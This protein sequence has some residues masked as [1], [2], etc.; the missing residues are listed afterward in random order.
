MPE[1]PLVYFPASQDK[2]RQWGVL[3]FLF[4]M[5]FFLYTFLDHDAGDTLLK[6]NY[7]SGLALHEAF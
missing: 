6:L 4:A 5:L 3:G 7:T 1:R 2:F